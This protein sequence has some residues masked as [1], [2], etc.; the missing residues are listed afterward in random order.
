M[1]RAQ[2]KKHMDKLKAA[3]SGETMDSSSPLPQT[4]S[5]T[6]SMGMGDKHACP[7]DPSI[8]KISDTSFMG[9]GDKHARPPDPSISD[10]KH[11][12]PP[13]PARLSDLPDNYLCE[14]SPD[15]MMLDALK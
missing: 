11:A 15:N 5:D 13:D 6:D 2:R 1:T 14:G 3:L 10:V 8:Q 9:L 12:Q 7:P 4:N